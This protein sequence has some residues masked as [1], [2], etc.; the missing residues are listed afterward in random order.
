MVF[1]AGC[2]YPGATS[3]ITS[4]IFVMKYGFNNALGM[5]HQVSILLSIIPLYG[6]AFGFMF[7][8]K[9]QLHAMALS[10]MFPPILKG[11]DGPNRVP[12]VALYAAGITQFLIYLIFWSQGVS[13]QIFM[14]ATLAASCMYTAIFS[15]FITFRLKFGSMPRDFISPFG[16][17]GAVLGIVIFLMVAISNIAFQNDTNNAILVVVT[18][19][20][21]MG[22]MAMYYYLVVQHTQYFSPE[23]QKAFMKAYVVNGQLYLLL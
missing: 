2:Q 5:S 9:H 4:D 10:G 7:A 23:E 8:S 11:V 22:L 18:Y 13:T 6:S 20:G 14:I 1:A 19:F 17:P 21:F 12:R 16:I 3:E 15:G